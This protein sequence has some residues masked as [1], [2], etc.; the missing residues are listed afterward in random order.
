MLG[1]KPPWYK[2]V[3]TR[4]RLTKAATWLVIIAF[5]VFILWPDSHETKLLREVNAK[6]SDLIEKFPTLTDDQIIAELEA[7]R[8]MTDEPD[9]EPEDPY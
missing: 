7:I 2:T 1:Y 4:D 8:S 5:F 3:V 6:T 9:P